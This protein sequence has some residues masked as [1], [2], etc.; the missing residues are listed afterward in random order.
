MLVPVL[1]KCEAL[2]LK[3]SFQIKS[4]PLE[5]LLQ[6][7]LPLFQEPLLRQHTLLLLQSGSC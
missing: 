4:F 1:D 6:L 7:H 3:L 2:L 5:Q